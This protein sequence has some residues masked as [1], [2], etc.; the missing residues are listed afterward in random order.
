MSIKSEMGAQ[1]KNC[2]LPYKMGNTFFI[3]MLMCLVTTVF[4]KIVF[5]TV[6]KGKMDQNQCKDFPE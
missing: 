1:E 6:L 4:L 2:L 3:I 5:A